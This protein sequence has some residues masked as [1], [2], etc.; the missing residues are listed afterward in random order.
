MVKEL[1][2]RLIGG[3]SG[4][5]EYFR[6]FPSITK[7]QFYYCVGVLAEES[8]P[9]QITLEHVKHI[10]VLGCR[11]PWGLKIRCAALESFHMDYT[12]GLIIQPDIYEFIRTHKGIRR[13]L[14]K[15]GQPNDNREATRTI[16]QTRKLMECINDLGNKV[17]MELTVQ[18]QLLSISNGHRFASLVASEGIVW[19]VVEYGE[20]KFLQCAWN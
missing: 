4:L 13:V 16:S 10:E 20:Q 9:S 2:V 6:L 12:N 7:L 3:A 14:V 8:R 5:S 17:R 15:F 11:F 19:T 18:I 1:T